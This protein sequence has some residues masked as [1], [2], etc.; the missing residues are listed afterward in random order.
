[1]K[2]KKSQFKNDKN[3]F[4]HTPKALGVS[5]H[6]KHGFTLLVSIIVTGILLLVSFVVANVA[7]KQLILVYVGAESQQAFYAADSGIECAEYWDT[8]NSSGISSFSSPSGSITCNGQTITSGN[9]TVSTYPTQPS[10][11]GGASSGSGNS[12]AFVSTDTTTG[13]NWHGVYGGDGYNIFGATQS[14]PLYV[15]VTPTGNSYYAWADPVPGAHA[16]FLYAPYKDSVTTNRIAA[17]WYSGSTFDLDV[18]ISDSANHK[19]SIYSLDWDGVGGGRTQTISVLDGDTLAI[20]S[21]KSLSGFGN[22]TY[23]TWNISGHVKFRITNTNGLANATISGI[24]FD[25]GVAGGNTN[26][27]FQVDYANG[28]AIVRVSKQTGGLTTIDSRG[29]N[30]CG[31][32]LRK[33]ERGITI[34]Y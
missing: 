24:F 19:V 12:A 18:S 10:V 26:S 27:I 11:I 4:T 1:M 32:S 14:Y 16:K 29:Y 21:T 22:G 8:K 3:S 7:F 33:F 30:T 17:T 34:T 2:N 20:L 15:S 6:S 28:C 31:S 9:Q 23:L 5:L 25:P 13:G